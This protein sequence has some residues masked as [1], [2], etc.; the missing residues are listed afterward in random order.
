RSRDWRLIVYDDGQ[1]ELYHHK[2]DPQEHHNLADHPEYVET[3]RKLMRWLPKDA[4]PEFKRKSER[5]YRSR[6]NSNTPP[7]K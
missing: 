3:Q 1:K 2:V 4:A 5:P 6:V 7:P